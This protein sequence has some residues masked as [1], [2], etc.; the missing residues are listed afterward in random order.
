MIENT[1]GIRAVGSFI[2]KTTKKMVSPS[3]DHVSIRVATKHETPYKMGADS[4][5]DMVK[6]AEVLLEELEGQYFFFNEESYGDYLFQMHGR[7]IMDI[8]GV[9]RI[10]SFNLLQG[11]SSSLM[12]VKLLMNHLIANTN[13]RFGIVGSPQSWEYH[14]QNRQL[15]N[16]ILG[17]GAASLILEKGYQRNR[18]LSIATKTL[19]KYHDVLFNEVGGWKSPIADGPCKEGKFI[20]KIQ[21]LP[22]YK[23]VEESNFLILQNVMGEALQKAHLSFSDISLFAIHSPTRLHH[24]RFAKHFEISEEMIIDSAEEYGFMCSAGILLSIGTILENKDLKIGTKV[25][26]SSFGVDGNWAVMIIEI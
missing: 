8:V 11:G 22:H 3:G 15:G 18:I 7:Q 17:D 10:T 1:I 23:E 6:K 9:N 2:P 14:S 13:V 19:G 26:V 20:Y 24:D 16:A 4:I 21:N 12:L 25:M 5:L